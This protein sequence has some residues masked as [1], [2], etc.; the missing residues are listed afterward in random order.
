MKIRFWLKTVV[1]AVCVLGL[2]MPAF[3]KKSA[4][5]DNLVDVKT[6]WVTGQE[7]FLCEQ[8]GNRRSWR[9]SYLER[10]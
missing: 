2:T 6:A 8:L 10:R 3:A 1:V 7:S 9:H 5:K 4:Q